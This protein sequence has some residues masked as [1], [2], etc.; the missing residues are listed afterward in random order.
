MQNNVQARPFRFSPTREI[1][2][3]AVFFIAGTLLYSIGVAV[4]TAPN[5]IAPGGI[6]GISTILHYLIGSPL[7]TMITVLNIPLFIVAFRFLGKSFVVKT[8]IC[9]V[10][11]SVFTDIL[12]LS[13]IPKYTENVLL[14][15]LYGGVLSGAGLGL[16]F[17][18][19]GTTGGTDILSRLLR[20]KWPHVPMGRMMLSIDFG[21]IA[22]SALVFWDINV[23]LF[24]IIVEFTSSRVIDS[25]LYGADNG[26]MALIISDRY[27]DVAEAIRHDLNRGITLLKGEGYYTGNEHEVILCAVRRTQAARLSAIVRR[28][29]PQAFIIMCSADEVLG[30]GFKSLDKQD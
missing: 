10:L 21:V 8:V 18:R 28:V 22:L 25:L 7:G 16:V 6:T 30:L 15:A 19:G 4:F 1:L 9:T 27:R 14:A 29:D 2:K 11:V 20:R 13:F 12:G 17:L 5:K 23:A 3:D 26:R 24:A